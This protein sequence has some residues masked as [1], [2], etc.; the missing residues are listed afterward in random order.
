MLNVFLRL[1]ISIQ[2]SLGCAG[3]RPLEVNHF[4]LLL[5][6][7][8]WIDRFLAAQ[9]LEHQTY[10]HGLTAPWLAAN[11]D[12][13]SIDD[14]RND[15]EDVFLEG[16]IDSRALLQVHTDNVV[17]LLAVDDIQNP[18]RCETGIFLLGDA[19]FLQELVA[20]SHV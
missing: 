5:S 18:L 20:R 8:V 7:E 3:L 6:L 10:G 19:H 17:I 1:L 13:D 9:I 16:L 11:E 2:D 4:Q 15:C 14:A 12:R